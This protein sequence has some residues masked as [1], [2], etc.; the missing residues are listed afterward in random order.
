MPA[1]EYCRTAERRPIP[2]SKKGDK[3]EEN[4]EP[5]DDAIVEIP[6]NR[7]RFFGGAGKCCCLFQRP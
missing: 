6:N 7:L 2:L 3:K 5:K 4:M 1:R